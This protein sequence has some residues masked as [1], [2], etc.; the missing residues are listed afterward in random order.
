MLQNR[1]MMVVLDTSYTLA[2]YSGLTKVLSSD[3][4]MVHQ[5][6]TVVMQF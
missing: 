5:Q 3:M 1:Q 2:L 6:P 4:H